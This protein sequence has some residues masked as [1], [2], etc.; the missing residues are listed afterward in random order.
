VFESLLGQSTNVAD[1]S[2]ADQAP[3][4]ENSQPLERLVASRALTNDHSVPESATARGEKRP[5]NCNSY[6]LI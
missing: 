5:F 3:C 4:R 6:D 1:G 2:S